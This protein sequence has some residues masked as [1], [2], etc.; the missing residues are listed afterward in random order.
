MNVI[1][2]FLGRQSITVIMRLKNKV[3]RALSQ[4][5]WSQDL[6]IHP[7][8]TVYC[9][10]DSFQSARLSSS[11]VALLDAKEVTHNSQAYHINGK[12]SPFGLADK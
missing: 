4:H 12:Y 10:P 8:A 2:R 5:L 7:R 9:S 1:S 6:R 11:Q 3:L